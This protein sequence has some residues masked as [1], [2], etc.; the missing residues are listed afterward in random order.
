MYKTDGVKNVL[1]AVRQR[2]SLIHIIVGQV[3]VNDCANVVLALGG[4][5]ITAECPLEVEQI[6]GNADS[7]AV[8]F[9]N[10]TQGRAEAIILSGRVASEKNI[11]SVIDVVGVTCSDYRVELAKKFIEECKPVVIKGNISEIRKM[12]S[13]M[14]VLNDEVLP[15]YAGN[16]GIDA[17]ASDI[18]A[19]SD[20]EKLADMGELVRH[21]AKNT[22][23]VVLASGVVDI[24]SDGERVEYVPG[25]KP[26]MARVT[27]TGCMLNS[28]VAT[29]ISCCGYRLED[30]MDA[31]VCASKIMKTCGEFADESSGLG[32][33]RVNLIDAISKYRMF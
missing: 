29:T 33:Y 8:S 18:E 27:G 5:P 30:V 2:K 15:D 19:M 6:T 26:Q 10:I 28:A 9:A 25:G 20:E 17:S 16:V 24:V 14:A 13:V 32:S 7:L 31:V 22:G 3:S 11:P 12:A 4:R 1:E 23:A 21:F